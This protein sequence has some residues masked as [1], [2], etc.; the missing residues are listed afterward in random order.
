V[1]LGS[2]GA[3]RTDLN[4]DALDEAE[5]IAGAQRDPRAFLPLYTRYLPAV[6]GY[7]YGRLGN[8]ADAEGATSD[9]FMRALAALPRYRDQAFRSWLFAIAHHVV[10]DR[11]REKRPLWPLPPDDRA[12]PTAGPD[13]IV[14]AAQD[15]SLLSSLLDQLPDDQRHVLA[16][17]L[18]GLRST[19]VARMLDCSPTA[20]RSLQFRAVT[21]LRELLDAAETKEECHGRS[22]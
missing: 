9:V 4:A 8:R 3:R 11:I 6:Y 18:S 10:V 5:L 16:L 22:Q 13:E 2:L 15:R 14:L 12:D 7:C 1:V 19:E 17:R 20:V 21:R